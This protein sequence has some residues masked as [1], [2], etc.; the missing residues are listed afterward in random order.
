MPE[1]ADAYF[2]YFAYGSCMCPV[3]L[4]RT[5][6][7]VASPY[8]VGPAKLQ[9][10]RLGFYK[11]SPFRHCGT[12]D[13]VATPGSVVEG[14]LYRLPW[15]WSAAL[16][17]REEV[18]QNGY[19]RIE[20]AVETQHSQ[21]GSVRTYEVIEKLPA[22]IAPNDWYF[23]V[24]MRGAVTCG[25]SQPYC[26]QLFEHMTRLVDTAPAP[27]SASAVSRQI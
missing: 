2:N 8:V 20:V 5:F 12:L 3:D 10:Y 7:E 4:K 9:G 23:N 26:W 15:R 1:D 17:Q 19:R 13:I 24:V 25:L 14:V 27:L 18:P 16:D 6:G 21:Y 11:K 22:E